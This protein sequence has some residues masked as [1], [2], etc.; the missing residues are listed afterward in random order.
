MTSTHLKITVELTTETSCVWNMS[1]VMDS[2]QSNTDIILPRR[3]I[4]R[5]AL[6]FN[7][8]VKH[9]AMKTNVGVEV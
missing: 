3:L 4:I 2:L 9:H 6:F 7:F 1:R 5:V 8:L